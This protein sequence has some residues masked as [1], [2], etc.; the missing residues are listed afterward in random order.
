MGKATSTAPD[1]AVALATAALTA[2]NQTTPVC[3]PRGPFNIA[4]WGTFTATVVV[5][6]S[7]DGGTTWIPLLWDPVPTA[8]SFTAPAS[9][10]LVQ[11]EQ[12]VQVRLRCSAYT[13]GAINARVSQ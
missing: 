1:T 10:V 8:L 13:S 3:I 6:V 11:P 12:D 5:E 7:F 9:L 4:I 2:L